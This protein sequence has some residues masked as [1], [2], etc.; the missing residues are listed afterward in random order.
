MHDWMSSFFLDCSPISYP[1]CI[2]KNRI[3]LKRS[4]NNVLY[5]YGVLPSSMWMSQ[6]NQAMR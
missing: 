3:I 6:I 1:Y 2:K 5:R 4:L